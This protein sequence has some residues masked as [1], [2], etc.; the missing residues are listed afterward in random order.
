MVR[1]FIPSGRI[2]YRRTIGVILVVTSLL[3]LNSC[4]V[5]TQGY[6]LVSQQ[7]S[8]RRIDSLPAAGITPAEQRLFDEVAG[9]RRF[10]VEEIGLE[11]TDSY[12]TFYRTERDHLVD[13]VS[14]AREFSFDRKLWW[15]PFFGTFPYKGFYRREP[16]ER[17]ARRLQRDGWDVIIRRVDAFSTL[18]FF[19]D[20]LV[21]FMTEYDTARVAELVIHEMAHATLWVRGEAQ[22]N[23]EFAT[24]VGRLGAEAYL[25][26]RFGAESPEIMQFRLER[27]DGD[28][29]RRDVFE[30]KGRLRQL[31]ASAASGTDPESRVDPSGSSAEQLR[32]KKAEIIAAYQREFT[33]TYHERYRT[34]RYLFFS[35]ISVNN[36]YLDLFET[37]TGNL[38]RLLTFHAAI[39]GGEL[40]VTVAELRRRV[41]GWSELPRRERRSPG[42]LEAAIW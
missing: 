34:D 26:D 30:L 10:A 12:T 6:H 21:S 18:G 13:V 28:R 31:Y 42:S 11:A 39:G 29:F 37:Y 23:E 22:F 1:R 25:I 7:L 3:F 40:P 32:T 41:E 16:A 17:L 38:D 33:A 20:P 24:M 8:S 35:E 2:P 15:F 4:Y 19:R 36:A 5:T 9:I 27:S 14:A